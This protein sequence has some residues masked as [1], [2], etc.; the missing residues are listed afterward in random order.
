M[1]AELPEQD[2]PEAVPVDAYDMLVC[3]D[4]KWVE[5]DEISAAQLVATDESST[6]VIT[7]LGRR[8]RSKTEPA[9]PW[10]E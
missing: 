1:H 4:G 5:E 8:D 2:I 9:S 6:T 7:E 3:D 10:W